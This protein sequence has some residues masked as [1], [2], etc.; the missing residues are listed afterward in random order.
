MEVSAAGKHQD[1]EFLRGRGDEDSHGKPHAG[2]VPVVVAIGKGRL[3]D[4]MSL[5]RQDLMSKKSEEG[6]IRT[7]VAIIP[8]LP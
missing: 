4:F 3:L 7:V 5:T 2:K 8:W 6:I 1:V